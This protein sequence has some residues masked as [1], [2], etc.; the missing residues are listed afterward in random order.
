MDFLC[1]QTETIIRVIG[2]RRLEKDKLHVNV[3]T[4][5]VCE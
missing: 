4:P 5:V 1:I 2:E 3:E